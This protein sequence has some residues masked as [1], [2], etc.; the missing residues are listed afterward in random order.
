MTPLRF[1]IVIPAHNEADHIGKTLQSLV[2][3]ELRPAAV[4]VVNDHSSDATPDI[5]DGF[6]QFHPWIKLVHHS[7]SHDHLPGAKIVEA[8]YC[9]FQTLD[10]QYDILCK[11]DADLVFEKNYLARLSHH[12]NQ[13]KRLGMAAGQCY[14][15]K[16]ET[17]IPENLHHQDHIRGAL[18]AYRKACFIDIG[19]LAKSIGWDTLDEQLARYYHWECLVDTTLK[20]KHLKPTGKNYTPGAEQLQGQATYRMRLGLLLTAIIALKRTWI[21]Q[22]PKAFLNHLQGYFKAKKENHPFIVDSKQ[23]KFLRRH[24]WR[25]IF[26]RIK[27]I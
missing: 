3:Q 22:K 20:V 6:A 26:Q 25:G 19:Q 27:S 10:D 12:F 14:L 23:G 4:V 16:N 7:S 17:W 9:G 13:N 1:Y 5:A 18:K 2:E 15:Q 8:F 11:F 21:L 24:R